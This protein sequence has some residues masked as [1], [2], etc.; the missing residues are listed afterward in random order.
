VSDTRNACRILVQKFVGKWKIEE[1]GF[2]DL[3]CEAQRWIKLA[4]N[5]A[6]WQ[7]LVFAMLNLQVLLS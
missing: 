2:R 4:Q 5:C 6:Q 7:A 3:G 1:M